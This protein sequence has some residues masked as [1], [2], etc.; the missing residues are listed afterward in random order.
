MDNFFC[1]VAGAKYVRLYNHDQTPKLYVVKGDKA[2]S[3]KRTAR[4]NVSDVCVEHPDF[5][6]HPLFRDAQFTHTI[7]TPGDMLFLP[8]RC[9]HYVRSLSTSISVNFWF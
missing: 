1:Q 3:A 8:T 9:W 4:G 2:G 6:R 5:D 7:M